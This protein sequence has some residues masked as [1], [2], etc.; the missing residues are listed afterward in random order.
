MGS[1][2]DGKLLAQ[3]IKGSLK[4]EVCAIKEKNGRSPSMVN[5]M[6]GDDHG[7]CAYAN[8]QKRVAEDLGIDYRL[9]NL[10][11]DITQDQLI[12]EIQKLDQDEQVNGILLHRPVPAQID[13]N[14]VANFVDIKKDLEGIN[15]ANVGKMLLGETKIIPCT[16]ASAM[17]HIKSTGIDLEGK[18]AVVVGASGIVGKPLSLLLL[19]ALLFSSTI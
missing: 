13:Y 18:E 17:E 3:K 12:S 10:K 6:I 15:I 14:T 5:V 9:L 1:I 8:S 11:D 16:P 19:N 7:A 4:E 2:L